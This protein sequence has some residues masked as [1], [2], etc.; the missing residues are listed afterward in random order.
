MRVMD[1]NRRILPP[2]IKGDLYVGGCCLAEGYINNPELTA[3]KFISSPD[4]LQGRLYK[5]GDLACTTSDDEFIIFGRSDNQ[6]KLHG[7]RIELEEIEAKI[8]TYPDIKE[9]AVTVFH[10]QLV[11]YICCTDQSAF[12]KTDFTQY[13]SQSLPEYMIPKHII[14]LNQLPKT[15]GGKTDRKALPSPVT[16]A[17]STEIVHLTPVQ[18]ALTRF[19]CE[20]LALEKIGIHDNFFELGGH[21]LL[22]ARITTKVA[23]Q[24]GKKTQLQDFHH[25]PT[26]E[27][28]AK[29][30]EQAPRIEQPIAMLPSLSRSLPLEDFQFIFWIN[31]FYQPKLKI[32]NT[33]HRQRIQGVLNKVALDLALQLILQ[34]Q[35]IF[36]YHIHSFYPIQ[37]LCTKPELRSKQWVE[38]SLTH[39]SEAEAESYLNERL[40]DLFFH[41]A[42]RANT[43]WIT[44]DLYYLHHDQIELQVCMPHLISDEQSNTIF[45][46]ELSRAYLFFTQQSPLHTHNDLQSY[47]HYILQQNNLVKTNHQKDIDFWKNYLSD[48]SLFV[49]PKQYVMTKKFPDA[50]HFP[51]PES[52]MS[53][54]RRLCIDNQLGL[55]DILSA[56]TVMALLQCCKAYPELM[57]QN[58]LLIAIIKAIRDDAHYDD[59]IGL[60]VRM[61]FIKLKLDSQLDLLA[62]AKQAQTSALETSPHQQ[63]SLL[64]KLAS[65]GQ[66]LPLTNPIKKFLRYGLAKMITKFYPLNPSFTYAL[67]KLAIANTTEQ[68]LINVNVLNSFLDAEH[69]SE[70]LFG[71]PKKEIPFSSF[72]FHVMSNRFILYFHRNNGQ[73]KP[74]MTIATNLSEDFQV[75]FQ[76]TLFSI[77]DKAP[78][79]KHQKETMT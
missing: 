40:T 2:Y 3:E 4:A 28:F 63:A 11:A 64:A 74:Y 46:K 18:L 41:Q 50:Q 5:T 39:L 48:T 60:F 53:N 76:K 27:Q 65:V 77:L 35:E 52:L 45:F 34:K 16:Q 78:A 49:F 73:N 20:E 56:A 47:H 14:L 57:P 66:A 58:N 9:G 25:A 38:K 68:Y 72:P 55:N 30:I 69:G 61:E 62:M 67:P 21:S 59:L 10:E 44:T 23:Q 70:T 43:S 32:Y 22:A 33:V 19:W 31:R 79:L 36:S 54:L 17:S 75:N 37:T 26:I 8:Q 15:I 1:S 13:L 71:L 6:I 12:S 42:W 7:Y 24:L 29:V 51:L